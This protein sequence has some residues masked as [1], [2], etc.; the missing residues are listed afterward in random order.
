[1]DPA[2][3][4]NIKNLLSQALDLPETDR[5][6]FL[7]QELD[8][9]VRL[10][11]EKLIAAHETAEDFIEKPIFIERGAIEE[12][13]TDALIGTKI[14]NYLI[15]EKI[16][17]GGMGTVYLAERL[18][19]DF[20]QKAALKVIKRGMD[21]ETIVKRFVTERKILSSLKH[22]NIAQ[23]IDGGISTDGRP[24]FVMEFIEGK[25]L[26]QFCEEN[27]LSLSER[28]EIFGQICSAVDHA[29]RNLT[30]HR[31]LKPSNI[32]ITKDRVPK[33]LDFGIAKL[34]SDPGID[35]TNSETTGKMFTPEYAA[36]EQLLGKIVTTSADVYSLGVILYELLT[37]SRPYQ[38]KGKSYD[39]IIKSVCETDPPR[40]SNTRS[41][42]A[43]TWTEG[44]ADRHFDRQALR[45]DLDNIILKSMRKEPSERYGSVQLLSEDIRRF[46]TG[47]PVLARPQTIGYR[48]GKYIQ[49]HKIGVAAA[50]IVIVSLVAGTS[51]AT[52]QA[53]VAKRERAKAEER[54]GDVRT[55][56]N[57]LMFD[58][59]DS[60]KDLAGSTPARKL[61]VERALNYLDKLTVESKNDMTLQRDLAAGYEKIGDV[62]G[63]SLGSNLGD[64]SGAIESYGKA[65]AIRESLAKD[66]ESFDEHYAAAMLHS[67]IFRVMM[68]VNDFP[69]AEIHCRNAIEILEKLSIAKPDDLLIRLTSARFHLE[70][71]ELLVSKPNGDE[72]DAIK[73]Y[74]RSIAIADGI[75]DSYELKKKMTDGLSMNE[76]ILSVTQ[77]AYRRIGQNLEAKKP[78]EAYKE[79]SK[80]LESSRKLKSANDPPTLQSQIVFAI[81]LGNVGRTQAKLGMNQEALKNTKQMLEICE[82]AVRSDPKNYLAIGQLSLAHGTLGFVYAKE[83]NFRKALDHLQKSRQ[84]QEGNVRTHPEDIY[85]TGNLGETLAFI[86]EI[87]EQLAKAKNQKTSALI[88]AEKWHRRS[89]DIWL[90]LKKESK[91]PAYFAGKIDEQ[92]QALLRCKAKT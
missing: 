73:N 36:P 86:G 54:F 51:V 88:E 74:R 4:Q 81:A 20:N 39:E 41:N 8:V 40:P 60:I 3:W 12:E 57:S 83:K 24:F 75:P 80:A 66:P 35:A 6:A 21:S 63:G 2:H 38:I 53:T 59:H 19:S 76:K 72:G 17:A 67:K 64:S 27:R 49:R 65:L 82:T 5:E 14:G 85:N 78:E 31:D 34:L 30:I 18:D 61:L 89:L 23:L 87:Y 9:E 47:L 16:G 91:L 84:I 68:Q 56:A 32:L 29:H 43:I 46:L 70:L 44:S 45:G 90:A 69:K 62:Q 92:N 71:G 28:L 26:N 48:F 15:L 10:E 37:G 52:W 25:P 13:K 33:L 50:A 1:M 11:V 22:K 55:L 7:A 58:V 79:Y 77:M 42:E